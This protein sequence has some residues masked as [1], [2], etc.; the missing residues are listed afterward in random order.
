MANVQ[1]LRKVGDF[2]T[3]CP[4][5]KRDFILLVKKRTFVDLKS[6]SPVLK[7]IKDLQLPPKAGLQCPALLLQILLLY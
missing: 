1:V 4:K 6:I 7:P 5:L 2:L 3:F